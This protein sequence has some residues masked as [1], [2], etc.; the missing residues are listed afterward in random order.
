[1]ADR[2]AEDD[3]ARAGRTDAVPGGADGRPHADRSALLDLA[4]FALRA[5]R[6]REELLEEAA[7]ITAAALGGHPDTLPER[8]PPAAAD[9]LVTL[10]A[11]WPPGDAVAGALRVTGGTDASPSGHA[12]AAG[13]A[14]ASFSE[15]EA[16][17]P[18]ARVPRADSR[19]ADASGPG[20]AELLLRGAE[21]L[22]AALEQTAV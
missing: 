17:D 12:E 5:T 19:R 2:C 22:G 1:M 18:A 9:S 20:E 21:V 11:G 13:T 14:Q 6:T 15:A 4:L 16:E 8:P 3:P 7:R 10:G